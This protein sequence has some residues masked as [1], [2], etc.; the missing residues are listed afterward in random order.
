MPPLLSLLLLLLV[1]GA[2]A[3]AGAIL[4][5]ARALI[6]PPRMTDG[7]A[8]YL[9]KRVSPADLGMTFED[10]TFTVRDARTGTPLELAAW[11]M[12]HPNANGRCAVLVHGYADAKVGS[13]AWAPTW[14]AL[15]FNVLAL[16]LRAHGESEGDL[17]TAGYAERHDVADVCDRLRAERPNEAR[18]IVIVGISLGA[19]A[20]VG[21]AALR[22]G[23]ADAV[24]LDS[25]VA[26]FRTA[27]LTHFDLLGLPGGPIAHWAVRAGE[28]LAGASFEDVRTTPLITRAKCPVMVIAPGQDVFVTQG[29]A[30]QVEQSV[31]QRGN[32]AD[33]YL[34]IDDTLHL[35]ALYADPDTYRQRL[36]AFVDG[37]FNAT[38]TAPMLALTPTAD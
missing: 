23:V 30:S 4:V 28:W 19:T 27:A 36:Q 22:D 11:W 24:V 13:I 14:R 1:I 7:K 5:M 25:P 26:D 10:V 2:L 3:S 38:A 18:Q 15:G 33:V 16:D 20:A 37:A 8:L 21:A 6:R 29:Q 32:S 17:C 34:R 31:V 12:P 35:E 9:L